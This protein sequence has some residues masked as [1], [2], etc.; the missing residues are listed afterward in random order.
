M[1]VLVPW[2]KPLIALRNEG[3][4]LVDSAGNDGINA[5]QKFPAQLK[6]TLTV[7]SIKEGDI[8]FVNYNERNKINSD[9]VGSNW[10]PCVDIFAPGVDI[11]SA[12]LNSGNDAMKM[13]GTSMAGK[14][15]LHFCMFMLFPL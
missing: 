4:L 2:D 14:R 9:F 6:T 5:C 10:G 7:A 13:T 15:Y 12:K 8:I 11:L 3:V 1:L